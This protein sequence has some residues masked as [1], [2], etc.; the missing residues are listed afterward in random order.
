MALFTPAAANARARDQT[1]EWY[2][3]SLM[4]HEKRSYY[5]G[6]LTAAAAH[7]AAHQAGME[8]QVVTDKLLPDMEVP[9]P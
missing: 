2:I 4:R 7:G 6:L 3:D 9:A 8:F 5:V 1:P